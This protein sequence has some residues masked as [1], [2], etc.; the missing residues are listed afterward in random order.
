MNSIISKEFLTSALTAFDKYK[1]DKEALSLRIRENN[2]WY[3]ARYGKIPWRKGVF[4]NL[5]KG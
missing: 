4:N 2:Y 1:R 5:R 3:K